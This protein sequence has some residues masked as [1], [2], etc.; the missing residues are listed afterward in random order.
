MHTHRFSATVFPSTRLMQQICICKSWMEM[1][2]KRLEF[3]LEPYDE[4]CNG[5]KSIQSKQLGWKKKTEQNGTIVKL[6]NIQMEMILIVYNCRRRRCCCFR[7][8]FSK[9]IWC[10]N[11]TISTKYST[12]NGFSICEK[13]NFSFENN[14]IAS[15]LQY[16]CRWMLMMNYLF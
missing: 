5:S 2:K 8:Q 4:P 14:R 13:K 3:R 10:T 11:H 1:G 16:S 9:W 15:S 6:L 7:C 12:T